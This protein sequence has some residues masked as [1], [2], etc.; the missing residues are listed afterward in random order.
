[1][2]RMVRDVCHKDVTRRSLEARLNGWLFFRCIPKGLCPSL[3]PCRLLCACHWSF[4]FCVVLVHVAL[5]RCYCC[6]CPIDRTVWRAHGGAVATL[7]G[8]LVINAAFNES[9]GVADPYFAFGCVPNATRTC[10]AGRAKLFSRDTRHN[11][12]T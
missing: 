6:V 8:Q 3:V 2:K 9:C 1:M 4:F 12:C 10:P 11:G 5:L 7:K